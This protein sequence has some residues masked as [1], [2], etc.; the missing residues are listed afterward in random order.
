MIAL[1]AR[2]KD[3]LP[4]TTA[5]IRRE[6]G[7]SKAT[8]KRDLQALESALPSASCTRMGHGRTAQKRLAA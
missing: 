3:G 7:V 1:T 4:V 5:Y 2:L 6:F 8:A